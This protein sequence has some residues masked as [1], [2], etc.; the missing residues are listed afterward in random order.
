MSLSPNAPTAMATYA[1]TMPNIVALYLF[2]S[3][4]RER[5]GPLSDVDVAVLLD[6]GVT[7]DHY[8]D[9]RLQYL[10]QLSD[11]LQRDDVDVLILNEAPPALAYRVLWDGKLLF[12][13]DRTVLAA[14]KAA[15]VT[16]YLDFEPIIKRHE[17][18]VL[19]RARKGALLDGYNPHRGALE[20]Y[21]RLR[22]RLARA[23]SADV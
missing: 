13:R 18:A 16:T 1:A 5:A 9:L 23:T 21:R 14:Y 11:Q 2:G 17:R 6:Q 4:A 22:E 15:T 12:C 8:F 19:E 20:R 3:Q 10:Q 7:A